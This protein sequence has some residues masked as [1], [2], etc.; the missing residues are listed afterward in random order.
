[1]LYEQ[2]PDAPRLDMR[3]MYGDFANICAIKPDI[4]VSAPNTSP[5]RILAFFPP[6]IITLPFRL[7]AAQWNY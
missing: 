6:S 4:P 5:G 1:M 2:Q 7:P 3:R